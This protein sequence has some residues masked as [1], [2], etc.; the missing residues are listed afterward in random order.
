MIK[1]LWTSATFT[2]WANT[3][4]R[5]VGALA[6]LP[7]VLRTSAPDEVVVWLLLSS[8]GIYAALADF[9]FLPTF[10]RLVAY[11][12]ALR[13]GRVSAS[14]PR[15]PPL[16]LES[17]AA[18]V[19]YFYGRI[20][21][22]TF[23]VLL[24]VGLLALWSPVEHVPSPTI[25]W[26]AA[27][28][29]LIGS[30]TA[31][32]GNGYVA[33]LAGSNRVAMVQRLM[34]VAGMMGILSGIAL[35]LAGFSAFHAICAQQV[36]VVAGVLLCKRAAR[37]VTRLE[38]GSRQEFA[39]MARD[40][41]WSSA[42]RSGLSSL[43]TIGSLQFAMILVAQ[44]P[45]KS[46]AATFLL[47]FRIAQAI[48]QFSQAPFYSRIPELARLH[49]ENDTDRRIRLARTSMRRS[50]WV[51][52]V[53]FVAAGMLG[54]QVLA[55]FGSNV[56]FMDPAMWVVLGLAMLGERYGAM[57]IQLYSTGGH[58]VWHIAALR[59]SAA[60]AITSVLLYPLIRLWAVPVAMFVAYWGF[61]A[62]FCTGRSYRAIGATFAGFERDVLLP[63]L[64]LMI[65][66]A[67]FVILQQWF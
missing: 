13:H 16:V 24:V 20:A 64:A 58:I 22:L 47:G 19:H 46:R 1:R 52:A 42:W 18:R 25:A 61:Y 37:Q 6:L 59:Y 23:I 4:V 66:S 15:D 53:T 32:Y 36:W 26:V 49:A 34:A 62:G 56:T 30:T 31:V 48:S 14:L 54:N 39:G 8:A 5:S 21:A 63:P 2:T 50:H 65:A 40:D 60:F 43:L 17:I 41:V 55:A 3:A 12:S 11:A 35:M 27:G 29:V 7:L 45:D 38:S 67:F 57:H 28:S 33:L 44:Y 51:F 10:T 9:G